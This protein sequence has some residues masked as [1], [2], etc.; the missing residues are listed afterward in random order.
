MKLDLDIGLTYKQCL[1]GESVQAK[2][3]IRIYI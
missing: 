3:E 2:S 1:I